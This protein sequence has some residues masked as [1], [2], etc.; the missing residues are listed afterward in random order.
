MDK[1]KRYEL[2]PKQ[3]QR[4][5][6]LLPGKPDDP[7]RSEA[8]NLSF[9]NGVLCTGKCESLFKENSFDPGWSPPT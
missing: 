7:D 1:P 8:D 2:T 4:L 9:V 3:W 6:P 5:G